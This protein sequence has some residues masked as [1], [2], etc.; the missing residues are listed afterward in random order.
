MESCIHVHDVDVFESLILCS[1]SGHED[2]FESL[3]LCSVSVHFQWQ[4]TWA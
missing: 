2:V 4:D 3:I 1:V